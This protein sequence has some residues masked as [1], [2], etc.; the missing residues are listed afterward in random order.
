MNYP[1]GIIWRH[2]WLICL[3]LN[4]CRSRSVWNS[5]LPVKAPHTIQLCSPFPIP[6]PD[7]PWHP[8]RSNAT[9]TVTTNPI[10]VKKKKWKPRITWNNRRPNRI[11][12]VYILE[13]RTIGCHTVW[14][15]KNQNIRKK[16]EIAQFSQ[17]KRENEAKLIEI[18][19]SSDGKNPFY[20]NMD[21][22][23]ARTI[24]RAKE[25]K[26]SSDCCL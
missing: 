4:V 3:I 17:I 15:K 13:L 2:S 25:A 22:E 11:H 26:S 8:N 23:I 14:I 18:R 16:N 5:M 24:C 7:I 10:E 19:L 6:Y 1:S 20:L 21:N 9:H 12:R